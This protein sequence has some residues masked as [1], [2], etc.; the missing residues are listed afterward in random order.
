MQHSNTDSC[1]LL[2]FY[3]KPQPVANARIVSVVVSYWN[4]TSNHNTIGTE[5][6]VARV[7]SYWNSTSNHNSVRSPAV[8]CPVVSYWNSTSNHNPPSGGYTYHG[9]ILLK[10]YI[11]P[12]QRSSPMEISAVVSYWN[13]TSNHNMRHAVGMPLRL[14]LIEILHQTTTARP[15]GLRFSCCILLK[16]YIKP[17]LSWLYA[18]PFCVVSYWNSTSNHNWTAAIL[19]IGMLYLI[20]ILHQTT[21]STIGG[22]YPKGCILLKFYIKPQQR[23]AQRGLIQVVSYWNS[24]SNHNSWIGRKRFP[25]LYLIEILHQTTTCGK[26]EDCLRRCILLKFYIKPQQRCCFNVRGFGCILLKF[27]IKPQQCSSSVAFSAS[28][29]LLKFYI[30]PQQLNWEKEVPVVVS[31]W[32]S[33]SNHNAAGA[34]SD[35][36]PLYLIEILHQTTTVGIKRRNGK[37]LYLIEI[38]HQ[39]TT[40]FNRMARFLGCILLKF[41][42]KPQLSATENYPIFCCILLKFYIKPQPSFR[43]AFALFVVSYW[44]STS[45]H[46]E[47]SPRPK[48]PEVVSYWNSTSNHNHTF[49]YTMTELVVSYWNSTSNHNTRVADCPTQCVVSY[50]NSTSNHNSDLITSSFILLYLIEILHQTTTMSQNLMK[51]RKLY[52][53]EI[54][55]QTTT[56]FI[57]NSRF[58]WLYLIEILHQTTTPLRAGASQL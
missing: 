35:G 42:I 55:H 15:A 17:Q 3:I 45:N 46:N 19:A 16:F 37:R 50:W 13:S 43:S 26:C 1:I 18:S 41:Y 52:L 7:V 53:I 48:P 56:Y 27:Y 9:C 20:E 2:K 33:T 51:K 12:Q 49:C 21:T 23:E 4:S 30:K 47:L 5:T 14:Y 24:T 28:C 32:N 38:L 36:Y 10:F 6:P 8:P 29:I 58:V 57:H 44:N 22:R 34:N 31:Y 40:V 25:S 39:T 54:L 11:K